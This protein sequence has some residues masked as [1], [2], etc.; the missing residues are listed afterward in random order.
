MA[1][2]GHMHRSCSGRS[3]HVIKVRVVSVYGKAGIRCQ[4]PSEEEGCM[5]ADGH[6]AMT[7]LTTLRG[8][9]LSNA[10]ATAP[11]AP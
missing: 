8:K 10:C 9:A 11:M 5:N 4:N 1:M 2:A 7:V 3:A 6:P